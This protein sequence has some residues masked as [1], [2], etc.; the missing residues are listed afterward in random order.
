MPPFWALCSPLVTEWKASPHWSDIANGKSSSYLYNNY[1]N[2]M[3]YCKETHAVF[4][5]FKLQQ[6]PLALLLLLLLCN[7]SSVTTCAFP[8]TGAGMR[9][10]E[11][12]QTIPTMLSQ[13]PGFYLP[14]VAKITLPAS[15]TA[16][17][18]RVAQRKALWIPALSVMGFVSP[19]TDHLTVP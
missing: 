5:L 4:S 6:T 18:G 15:L 3:H 14:T 17:R 16:L 8:N 10:S 11:L 12:P 13:S 2:V 19:C 1:T 7:S 9:G